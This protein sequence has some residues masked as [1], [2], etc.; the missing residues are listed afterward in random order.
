MSDNNTVLLRVQLDE[1]NTEQKLAKLVLEIEATRKAQA[2]LTKARDTDKISADDYA[3]QS[4]KLTNQLTLQRGEQRSLTKDLELYRGAIAGT[5]TSYKELQ[6]ALSLAQRQFQQL[7]GSADNSTESAQALSKTIEELRVRLRATDEVQQNFARSIGNYPKN[8]SLEKLVQQLVSLQEQEKRVTAGSQEAYDL[9][10]KIGF[11]QQAAIQR[12]AAEGKSYEQ[13]TDFLREY[14]EVIRPATADLIKLTE[15]QQQLATSGEEVTE[16]VRKIGFQIGALSKQIKDTPTELPEIKVPTGSL[17]ALA[18]ALVKIREQQKGVA[19]DSAAFEQAEREIKAYQ[20]AA[21]AAGGEAGMSYDKAKQR[22]DQYTAQV[23]PLV[24]ALVKL[25]A[26]QAEVA[27]GSEAYTKLQV[28]ISSATQALDKA[29]KPAKSLGSGLL[30]AAKNSEV[31]GGAVSKATEYQEKFTQAQALAKVAIGGNVT[32]LG[33]LRL[34]LL[35]TGLGALIVVLGSVIGFLTRT[36]AGTAILNQKL[37][38]FGAVV[39][40]V[41]NLA[42]EF[43]GKLVKAAEDPKQ[44]FSDLL[45]FIGNNVLNRIKSVGVLIDGIKSGNISQIGDSFIQATTGITNGTEKIKSFGKEIDAAAEAGARLSAM[46]RKLERDTNDNIDTNKKLLNEVERLKNIRDNEFNTLAVRQK[47]N[48]DAYKVE[49]QREG[50]LVEIARERIAVKKAELEQAGGRDRNEDL[51]KELKDAENELKDIQEDAAGKQNELITNRFQ[52][53]KDGLDK[54]KDL[55][56]KALDKRLALRKDALALEAQLLDR[57]LKQVQTNSDQ[58]LSLLQQKLRNGYQAELNVKGLTASAKKV[59]DAKYE[60]ESLALTLDFNR[61]KLQAALVAQSD[62]TAA[63]LAGQQAGSEEALKLQA[64]QIQEQRQQAIAE[65][66]ANADNTA[67]IAKINTTAAQQQRDLEYQQVAKAL[68]D[69]IARRKQLVEAAYADGLIQEREYQEK[70]AQLTKIG[71]DTQ[72]A[73]NKKYL[74]DNSENQKQIDAEDLAARRRHT[75]DVKKTEEAKQTIKEATVQSA[76]KATD[77]IITL[78]GEESAA[79][80]AA[81]A[82]RKILALAEIELNLQ[83]E[84]SAIS[85]AAASIKA[86]PIIGPALGTAY[87]ITEK[88]LAIAGAAASAAAVLKLEQGAVVDIGGGHIASGPRHAQGGIP[89]FRRGQQVG[90][91]IEGGEPVLTRSVSQNPLL[92][93]MAS[94]IN[95]LAGG[96]ALTTNFPVPRM[97]MGGVATPL[98]LDQLR[99]PAGPAIDYNRLAQATAQAL[100]QSP[101]HVKWVDFKAAEGRAGYTDKLANG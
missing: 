75:D 9:R 39:R 7:D 47:A 17:E 1:T 16:E 49:L 15:Q 30:D 29:N 32:V 92:L 28:R 73:I 94:A 56:A 90:I 40:V 84:L 43:G 3:L 22:L 71:T 72:T 37:A 81:M 52:L 80:Q 54:E 79:G 59:I 27:Q 91:E 74:Q 101:P 20:A 5:G 78:F 57:Q 67:A 99:G 96:R 48:E 70:L 51:Y 60:S 83:K 33:A 23:Q 98:V 65:L 53:T 46:Q 18:Q 19:T 8:D 89:L 4:V 41:T 77:T 24:A 69:D 45:D 76:Q 88:V 6:A 93:S 62:L 55:T 13:T 64:K 58:E 66:Q 36:Q 38:T 86:I 100:R 42:I 25:E 31:L 95:Q 26:E 68:Q 82:F 14:G 10:N 12:G 44:A 85:L 35:A 50:K 63:E 87:E 21:I 11:Q 97:A 61:R 34:A 2:A